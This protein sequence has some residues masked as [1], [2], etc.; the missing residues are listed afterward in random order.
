MKYS[1]REKKVLRKKRSWGDSVSSAV[2]SSIGNGGTV[3]DGIGEDGSS[4]AFELS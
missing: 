4:S 2:N 3:S 1:Y